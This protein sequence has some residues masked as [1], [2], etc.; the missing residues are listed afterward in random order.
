MGQPSKLAK[1]VNRPSSWYRSKHKIEMGLPATF[2]PTPRKGRAQC[3]DLGPEWN[4]TNKLSRGH[5]VRG[6]DN[7]KKHA[8]NLDGDR[9]KGTDPKCS[10]GVHGL[11][12]VRSE[13]LRIDKELY[14]VTYSRVKE[15]GWAVIDTWPRDERL[16]ER[17]PRVNPWEAE[18][19]YK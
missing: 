17:G 13:M 2:G 18:Q 16:L 5:D 3:G 4:P 9:G 7:F 8:I 14:S 10:R 19:C 12:S 6:Q 1:C 15:R 11:R